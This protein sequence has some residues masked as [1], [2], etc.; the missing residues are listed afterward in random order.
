[1]RARRIDKIDLGI[2][3]SRFSKNRGHD[4]V[5]DSLRGGARHVISFI[6]RLAP[7]KNVATLLRAMPEVL[8]AQP[9]TH[10][11]IAGNGPEKPGLTELCQALGIASAVTFMGYVEDAR[12][13]YAASDVFV[14]P[15]RHEGFGIVLAEAMAMETPIVAARASGIIDVVE[16]GKTALLAAPGDAAAFARA[17]LRLFNDASMRQRLVAEGRRTVQEKFSREN[18]ALRVEALYADVLSR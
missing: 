16:D 2:D 11:L 10:L 9:S 8:R 15:S 14:L 12:S 1:M 7:Q 4:A 3:L 18:M 17:I 5:S 13:V 6:G